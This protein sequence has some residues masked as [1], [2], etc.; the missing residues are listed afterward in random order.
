[1]ETQV[2][3]F[4]G[5][6]LDEY[7]LYQSALTDCAPV[8]ALNSYFS[9]PFRRSA[10]ITVTNEADTPSGAFYSNIDYQIF[11][12]LPDDAMYFLFCGVWVPD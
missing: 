4:F 9:M 2:G 3:D 10:R 12:D 5:L 11:P 1:M 6:T 7:V 8:K